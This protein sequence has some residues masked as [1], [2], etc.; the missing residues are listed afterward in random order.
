MPR[1]FV[2]PPPMLFTADHHPAFL[3]DMYRGR[4]AFLICGGPSFGQLDHTKLRQPGLLTMGLNNTPKTFRPHL[5]TSVDS[6]DHFLRSIWLDPTILKFV[7][8]CH[9]WKPIFDNDAWKWTGQKVSD[10]PATFFFRRNLAFKPE[11][12]LWED[13]INWGNTGK[14]G[15]ARSIMLIAIRLLFILGVRRVFLLG[16]DFHMSP[17]AKYHFNQDRTPASI[18]GNNHTYEVLNQRFRGLRPLFEAEG[19]HLYNCNPQSHLTAFDHV[20]FEKAVDLA[21]D[22]WG[23]IDTARE[24]S[25]GLY[26]KPKPTEPTKA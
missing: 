15:G 24:N 10:C 5:W 17:E 6:P 4:S 21:L 25:A 8:I 1:R 9:R 13:T 14:T 26:E 2:Q 19:F 18:S 23:W 22:E 20:P 7:P 11:Q 3:A 12:Y 16:A